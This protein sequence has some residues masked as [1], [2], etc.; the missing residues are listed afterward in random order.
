MK[1]LKEHMYEGLLAGMEDTLEAGDKFE[2]YKTIR[3]LYYSTD[4]KSLNKNWNTFKKSQLG[5]PVSGDKLIKGKLYIGVSKANHH[6]TSEYKSITYIGIIRCGENVIHMN[7][8]N[9][10]NPSPSI[11][12]DPGAGIITYEPEENHPLGI[13]QTKKKL[14]DFNKEFKKILN[15][16]EWYEVPEKVIPYIEKV[17]LADSRDPNSKSFWKNPRKIRRKDE[18]GDLNDL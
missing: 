14:L 10:I 12:F 8:S 1:T 17:I 11:Q 18:W 4:R 7:A 5:N 3:N 15:T 13:Y 2:T 9:F 16:F 6:F